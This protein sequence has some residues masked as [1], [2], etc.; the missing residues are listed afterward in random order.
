VRRPAAPV[1]GQVSLVTAGDRITRIPRP[2]PPPARPA[3]PQPWG[4]RAWRRG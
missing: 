1:P 3:A 2:H 4:R